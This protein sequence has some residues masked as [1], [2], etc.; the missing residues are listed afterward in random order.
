MDIEKQHGAVSK[1]AYYTKQFLPQRATQ[2]WRQH[3]YTS[4]LVAVVSLVRQNDPFSL[5]LCHFHR[6]FTLELSTA[7]A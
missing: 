7:T 2:S 6:A 4:L 3:C 5:L 1:G